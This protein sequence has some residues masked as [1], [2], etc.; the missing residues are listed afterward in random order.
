MSQREKRSIGVAL[1]GGGPL[2]AIWEVGALVALQDALVGIDLAECDV[3]VGVSSGAIL[4]AGLA[5]GLT[6]RDIHRMFVESDGKDAFRPEMLMRP[7]FG[8]YARRLARLPGLTVSALGRWWSEAPK[9]FFAS[10][11]R[12]GHAV[13]TGIFDNAGL[14]AFL[15]RLLAAPGRSND[16]RALR[17]RLFVVA[18]DL[19]SGHTVH[20]GKPGWDHVPIAEAVRASAAL[21]GLFP[22]VEIE[23]RSYVDGALTKTLHASVALKE[24]VKL[25]VCVNPLVPFDA[26]LCHDDDGGERISL[27][28]RGLPTVMSQ[29]FRAIIHS[30]MRV[31]MDRYRT[32]F[33]DA[34]VLLFEPAKSDAEMFFT[35][36]FSYAGRRRLAQHAYEKTL[37]DLRR[38]RDRLGPIL[39][40]HGVRLDDHVIEQKRPRISDA[41]FDPKPRRLRD[42]TLDLDHTLDRLGRTLRRRSAGH[43]G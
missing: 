2:G 18:T 5:N 28:E 12:L 30:R 42:A 1:A 3:H 36:I 33:P 8:E 23:G 4:A 15:A 21:P 9:G 25:L 6:P 11:H 20:F 26:D 35:N 40:R 22:P 24:G 41:P 19:D 10:F 37:A 39:A 7:A 31:G 38:D 14:S 16:F 32:E 13:P 34:D 29:T 27:V 17:H 43:G